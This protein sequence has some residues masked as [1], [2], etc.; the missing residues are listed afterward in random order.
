MSSLEFT[1]SDSSIPYVL[2]LYLPEAVHFQELTVPPSSSVTIKPIA[3]RVLSHS[4]TRRALK[5]ISVF[6]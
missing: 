5:G 3:E 4:D 1:G 2:E 6:T